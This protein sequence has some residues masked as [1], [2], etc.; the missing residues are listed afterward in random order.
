MPVSAP[1]RPRLVGIAIG[2]LAAAC[3][4]YVAHVLLGFGGRSS[5][6][7]E[8]WIYELI[9]AGSAAVCIARGMLVRLDRGAWLALGLALCL[10]LTGDLYWN[11]RLA[12]LDSPPYPS[13]ADA[14]WLA[15]YVP[16][17]VGIALLLR[18]RVGRVRVSQWLDGLIGVL[19]MAAVAVATV[20][21]PVLN[22]TG[23]DPAGVAT[24]LAYPVGDLVLLVFTIS[25]IGLLG[26]RPGRGWIVLA[27][28]LALF[29][30]SDS[31]YLLKAAD[32]SYVE[33]AILDA[34][35]P[36]AACLVAVAA[37]Q[38]MAAAR[39]RS[40]SF[41]AEQSVTAG[42]ALLALGVLV[43]DLVSPVNV[44]GHL[45]AVA[46]MVAIVARL[47]LAAHE[48]RRSERARS[49]EASTDELTGLANRRAFYT[50][51]ERQLEALEASGESAALLLMDLDHFKEFN[52]SL[53][54]G[55]GDE[56]LEE[57]SARLSACT[58]P[59]SF[60]AR[61]GGDEFVILLPAGSGGRE[62][63]AAALEVGRALAVPMELAG[64]VCH[65]SASIGIA[66]APG[67]GRDRTTLLRR[68]DIA[69][70]R[71]KRDSTAVELFDDDHDGPSRGHLELAGELRRAIE[72][73]EL[74]LHYQPKASLDGGAVDC[75]E[76]LVR[77][78][79]P[80]RGLLAP[81]TFLPIAERHGLMRRITFVVVESALGQQAAWRADGIDLTVAVNLAGADLLDTRFPQEVAD[82]LERFATPRGAL[83]FEIT[84]NTVMI[85][86]ERV[87][88]T[89]ARLGT[90]G[91]TF[92]L[93]DYGTGRSSLTY[94]KRLPVSE[95]KIDR[96]FVMD[97]SS[98][99]DNAVIVRSTIELARNLGMRVVAEGVETGEHWRQLAEYGCDTAQGFYLS[100]PLPA[101]EL[102]T[103][104]GVAPQG[105]RRSA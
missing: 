18:S 21:N 97:M 43:L 56:L 48:S 19:A 35:W 1:V 40:S 80:R 93:D 30:V 32:G 44:A 13:L 23:A 74:V 62:A 50:H 91:I 54:H 34:G 84:E 49:V 59:G 103:W 86:P 73:G 28:G 20:L 79:H 31:V 29:A 17:Y 38:P 95:L 41:A 46:A 71:A 53:G 36:I 100:R 6:L 89:L 61:L 51:F 102:T 85:D 10:Y 25:A 5:P 16:A 8:R 88:A 60:I 76:A 90:L 42:F 70:Y 22:V 94:L 47:V 33:G 2:A 82:L 81:D 37:W 9:V 75:V 55:A 69:M 77:W 99:N 63:R 104:L 105:S 92:A 72:Q 24:N 65:A 66:V 68:A 58:A 4:L 27:L 87:L 101:D 64:L 96:S 83:Q 98:A 52:D 45:L 78:Q 67:H 15:Y 3:A 26:W 39:E 7:F 57:V 12:E 14:G 11:A